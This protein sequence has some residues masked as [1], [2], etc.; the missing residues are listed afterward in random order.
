[1]DTRKKFHFDISLAE[2]SLNKAI[3]SGKLDNLDFPGKAK[4][5]GIA[6]VEY[7]NQLFI[8]KTKTFKE[9]GKDPAYL[10]EL[11]QRSRDNGVRNHL[12]MCD[13][14][15]DMGDP[16]KNVRQEAVENHFK[17]V[18]AAKYLGCT[19]I[20]VNASGKGSR[21]ELAKNAT[22]SLARLC[23]FAAK[24]NINVVLENHG[25]YSS[26]AQ[27][28]V[29]VV[30]AVGMPNC[31]TLPDFGNFCM[32]H[33]DPK[34]YYSP[35]VEEYDRYKGVEEM[36]PLAKGVSA[37][38]MDFDAAGHETTLD[39]PRLFNIIG[40]SGFEGIVGI[41]YSGNV[42]DED[43]GIRATLKLLKKMRGQA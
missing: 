42:L 25:G 9:N 32:K 33:A 21:D 24:A 6:A 30:K 39:Y 16:D 5:F 23:E 8:T 13:L 36:M 4:S 29:G 1:M 38:S 12:I 22:G 17:W 27:W 34:D 3:F 28:L 31:G 37:K 18:D 35:C 2:W 41:E 10:K 7:V 14:E 43:E 20:R 40:K 15:G 11:L 26:D 19:T